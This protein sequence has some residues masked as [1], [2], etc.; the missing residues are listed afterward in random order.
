MGKFK[1]KETYLLLII[2]LGLV[3]LGIYTTFAM[4]TASTTIND[5][6]GITT[7][8]DIGK[9]LTEYE[10]V[11]VQP[12]ETKLIELNVVNSYNGNIYY[13][14]W[15]QIVQG[16]NDDIQ[17]GLYTEKN[18]NPSSGVLTQNS[19]T[20]L[21][22]GITNNNSTSIIVY[23]G[24]KGSLT[25]ELNLGSNKVLLPD[26]FSEGYS[27]TLNVTNGVI[28]SSSSSTIK[29]KENEN[30]NFTIVP[31]TG[32]RLNIDNQTCD[33][34]L[35]KSTGLF[36]IN[37]ITGNKE[38]NV[39]ISKKNIDSS[40]ANDPE[41]SDSLIPVMY[42][43]SKWVK[44]DTTSSTSTY[45][46]YNYNNKKWANAALVKNYVMALNDEGNEKSVSLPSIALDSYRSTNGRTASSTATSTFT[47]TT[48][49]NSGTISFE[50]YTSK[51]SGTTLIKFNNTT[52]VNQTGTMENKMY[53][54]EVS[55]NSSYTLTVT[56][57]RDS[58][59][60]ASYAYLTGFLVPDGTTVTES[61]NTTYYFSK[62][63]TSYAS[64]QASNLSDIEYKND[65]YV[66]NG[67]SAYS[68]YSSSSVG[69]YVCPDTTATECSTL[70]KITE[71]TDDVITKVIEY[72]S[73]PVSTRENYINS[74]PGTE[75][76]ES[77]ILAYY[78]WIPRYKYK[79]WNIKKQVGTQSY[80]ARTQGIDIV[81]ESGTASTGTISC[82]YSYKSPSSRAGSPNETCTG[83][84][85]AYYTHPAFTF[86]SDNVKGFW[87]GKF[88]L[89]SS[90]P[91]TGTARGGGNTTFY[92]ARILPNVNGWHVNPTSNFHIVLQNMLE[93]NNIYG[94]STDSKVNDSHVI[95]N[96]E[97][98]AV[99]YLTNS[100]YGKCT[101]NSCSKVEMNGYGVISDGSYVNTKTGCGP[102]SSGST[103]YAATC[104]AYNTTLGMTASTTG[105]VFGV[106]DMNGGANELVMGNISSGSGS[107]SFHTSGSGFAS[108]WY[109]TSTAKY[110]TTYAYGTSD[111][112]QTAYNRGRLGDAI[113]EVVLTANSDTG[114][115]Y[116]DLV[117]MPWITSSSNYSWFCRGGSVTDST[118]MGIFRNVHLPGDGSMDSTTRAVLIIF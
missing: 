6:V 63:T 65:K 96:M 118:G 64:K 84:N 24:V 20:K 59:S 4:Y 38:C 10:V 61:H 70:Y 73:K 36:T 91:G 67:Y 75:I 15:Y 17:I 102:I 68:A 98:G 3:S 22:A 2:V 53:T 30:A 7:T 107:Y 87:M 85:G 117:Q 106:Y 105:N 113:S 47:I 35:D 79:V 76:T 116:S 37:N 51:N 58:S 9:S 109:T 112:N 60:T 81:F 90:Y 48:G 43:G 101:N 42:D 66:L 40:G 1:I 104:N 33:G 39:T 57:T 11:T 13:G 89:S 56:Y 108:S 31:N 88:E 52:I 14:A 86:G 26:G 28:N 44:A 32:Y 80:N 114:G 103:S 16:N 77:D 45:G 83:S 54:K 111:K 8:L 69:S 12:N 55:A 100:K 27:V 34:T 29:V 78:V 92:T 19:S 50:Y 18:P 62:S 115:W 25:N 97:W 23:L 94:L 71:V 21:L 72:T 93:E 99:A 46:W 49:A 74:T 41:T 110:L 5:V 95:T 82:T